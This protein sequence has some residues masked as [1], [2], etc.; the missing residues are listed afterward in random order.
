MNRIAI[1]LARG[2]S[3][4]IF[5]KNIK[6]FLGK[7]IISYS[8]SAAIQSSLFSE[9]MVST[10]DEKIKGISLKYGA[11]VPFMRSNKNSDDYATSFDAIKEVLLEYKK[12]NKHFDQGCCIYAAA[13]FISD[14][15]LTNA[16]TILDTN[17]FD[18]VFPAIKYS[19]PI[20]RSFRADKNGR[21]HLN[22]PEYKLTRT[23]DIQSAYH[24][25]GQFY[26]FNTDMIL[27]KQNL[28]TDNSGMIKISEMKAQDI[29][30]VSDWELAELKFKLNRGD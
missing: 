9:V 19:H 22:Y 13:P 1:I 24:D 5:R 28:I 20:Q 26:M 27:T 18:S 8:I 17:D 4:R 12:L 3:K 15:L 29:D 14:S 25:S 7:P 6:D 21:I 23:Q 2:S 11:K 30:E 10:D 16:L